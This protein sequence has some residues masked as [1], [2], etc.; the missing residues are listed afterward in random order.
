MEKQRR[1]N[2]VFR[3]LIRD[4]AGVAKPKWTIKQTFKQLVCCTCPHN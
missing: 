2:N 3:I 4:G 1:K